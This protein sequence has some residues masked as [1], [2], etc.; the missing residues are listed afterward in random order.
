VGCGVVLG[1]LI[2][3]VAM[4]AVKNLEVKTLDE[5][6]LVRFMLYVLALVV[7]RSDDLMCV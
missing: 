5:H 2:A 7:V 4:V 3:Q 1:L 6:F